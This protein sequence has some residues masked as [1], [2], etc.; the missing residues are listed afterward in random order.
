[1]S[2]AGKP[3]GD[4]MYVW[5]EKFFTSNSLD[6]EEIKRWAISVAGSRFLVL[7]REHET[8]TAKFADGFERVRVRAHV[9]SRERT[10]LDSKSW[11]SL[12][13]SDELS[14]AFGACLSLEIELKF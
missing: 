13:L 11:K 8:I 5:S 1:M 9:F 2:G 7:T 10:R 3:L 4:I 14:S 6:L 12:K